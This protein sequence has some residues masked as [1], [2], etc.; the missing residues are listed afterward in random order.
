MMTPASSEFTRRLHT[1]IATRSLLKALLTTTCAICTDDYLRQ[2]ELVRL[3]NCRHLFHRKCILPWFSRNNT[4][5][6]C[7]RVF[8]AEQ[9][10]RYTLPLRFQSVCF[11]RQERDT[12]HVFHLHFHLRSMPPSNPDDLWPPV[13]HLQQ[14]LVEEGYPELATRACGPYWVSINRIQQSTA[15]SS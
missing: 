5:P 1:V 6:L 12:D 15:G 3:P 8:P 9:P 10:K 4:C 7:R 11:N 13:G 2:D 14:M